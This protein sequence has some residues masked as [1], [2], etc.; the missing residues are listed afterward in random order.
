[1]IELFDSI[2]S[3]FNKV[4]IYAQTLFDNLTQAVS[5]LKTWVSYLPVELIA[6]AGII[7]VLL[8]IFRILGR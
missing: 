6:A 1:M 2:S 8:V 7:I 3:F 5:E 4:V